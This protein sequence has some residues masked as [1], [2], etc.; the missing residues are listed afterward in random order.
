MS[1]QTT[2]TMAKVIQEAIRSQILDLHTS[3]PGIV[4]SIN[5]SKK[6]VDVSLS[7]R[8]KFKDE[9]STTEVILADVPLG[10]LQTKQSVVSLP[11]SI[12]DDIWIMFSE[13]S[14]DNWKLTQ[15]NQPDSA[16][17]LSPDD[18][19]T[20][21]LSDAIAVPIVKPFSQG[22]AYDPDNLLIK[23][24]SGTVK[25]APSG[26]MALTDGTEEVISLMKELCD[27]CSEIITNTQIGPQPPINKSDFIA[28][29]NR[30]NSLII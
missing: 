14:L 26:K 30:I 20:H 25:I 9:D 13:R 18:V 15:D 2:P 23:N 4:R 28:L 3:L 6:T 17:I 29:S 19:R 11:V 1:T 5:T 16:R 27:T 21:H 8:R 10:T 24:Q 7:I 12:G 22:E